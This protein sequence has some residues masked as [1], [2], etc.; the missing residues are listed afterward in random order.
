MLSFPHVQDFQ[1]LLDS[2][3]RRISKIPGHGRTKFERRKNEGRARVEALGTSL[4]ST[5]ERYRKNFPGLVEMHPFHRALL[6]VLVDPE[7]LRKD[8]ERIAWAARQIDTLRLRAERRIERAQTLDAIEKE[9]KAAYGRISSVLEDIGPNLEGLIQVSRSTSQFPQVNPALPTVIVAGVPNVGKSQLVLAWTRAKPKVA[10]YPFTTTRIGLGH[11]EYHGQ[12]V[13]IMDTPGLLDRPLEDRGR[14]ELQA[15]AALRH[16][17]AVILF[18]FD[19]TEIC[20]FPRDYQEHVLQS[21][22]RTFPDQ[23]FLECDNK[24]DLPSKLATRTRISALKGKGLKELWEQA[25]ELVTSRGP[26][27][28]RPPRAK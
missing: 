5:L 8:L 27:V 7:S 14:S 16:L 21:L 25:G 24:S 20:G 15:I 17:R 26:A 9:K 19:S 3:F 22:K 1:S 28:S 11:R 12:T 4:K 6:E 23:L 18:L 2:N 13:Q 10:A